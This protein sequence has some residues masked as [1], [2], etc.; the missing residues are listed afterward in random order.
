ML[1]ELL[2]A[3]YIQVYSINFSH[4]DLND[5]IAFQIT[6]RLESQLVTGM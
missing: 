6:L 4:M 2:K 5:I 1:L 3:L